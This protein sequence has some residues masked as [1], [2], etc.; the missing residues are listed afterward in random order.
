MPNKLYQFYNTNLNYTGRPFALC[1]KHRGL[2]VVPSHLT[3][4]LLEQTDEHCN[5]CNLPWGSSR[6]EK[7]LVSCIKYTKPNGGKTDG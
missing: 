2:Y 5:L 3:M 6:R 1:E 7:E 4:T